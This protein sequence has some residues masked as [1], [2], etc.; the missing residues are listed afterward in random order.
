M[1]ANPLRTIA[2]HEA[3]DEAADH[4]HEYFQPAK[5]VARGRNHR[6]APALVEK[7]VGKNS[8][9]SQQGKSDER[10]EYANADRQEGNRDHFAGSGKVTQRLQVRRGAVCCGP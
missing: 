3:D 4:R 9:Q 8:N 10:T 1:T 6:G 7:Q 5:V 2:R